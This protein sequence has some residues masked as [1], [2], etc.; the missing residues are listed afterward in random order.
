M[1]ALLMHFLEEITSHC[2]CYCY[3]RLKVIN[4][5]S[6]W[7]HNFIVGE[8]RSLSVEEKGSKNWKVQTQIDGV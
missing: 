2:C 7:N 3:Y 5:T 1:S 6:D 8:I 4:Q